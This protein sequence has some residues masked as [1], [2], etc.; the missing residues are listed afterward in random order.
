MIEKLPRPE[1]RGGGAVY[2]AF[3]LVRL[4]R[5]RGALVYTRDPFTAWLAAKLGKPLIFEQHGVL[6]RPWVNRLIDSTL[7]ARSLRR[8]VLVSG[9]LEASFRSAGR[10]PSHGDVVVAHD[11]ADAVPLPDA[12]RAVT[13]KP[14]I[15]YVGNLYPGRGVD[16]VVELAR[17]IREADFE[18]V[19]GD[20]AELERLAASDLPANLRLAGFVSPGRLGERYLR[21]D[22]LLMP[23]AREV[24]VAG[25][26]LDTSRFMSPLKMF[27]YMAAGR[28]IVSSD[29]PV[30]REVLE[31]ERNALLVPP[32]EPELWER[33]VRRLMVESDLRRRLGRSARLDL[34]RHY[35]WAARA[36]RVLDGAGANH[37]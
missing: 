17:R 25:G 15:G 22:V 34:E 4:L 11:G 27:E 35:T 10:I 6:R 37:R 26:G 28:A 12:A 31:N 36:R 7:R 1:L 32:E 5:S 30:L 29:L 13:A 21:F 20:D 19:G 2:L 23:Y 24:M 14:R 3:V 33:A 8:L 16:L 9:Q 18:I